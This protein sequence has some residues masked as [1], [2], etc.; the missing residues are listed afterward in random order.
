MDSCYMCGRTGEQ[1]AALLAL[2]ATMEI[3]SKIAALTK[4]K[5]S[6]GNEFGDITAL[7][8]TLNTKL[9]NLNTD[10]LNLNFE[11]LEKNFGN[12]KSN[13]VADVLEFMKKTPDFKLESFS[14]QHVIANFEK[15][16][17]K[18]VRM[19]EIEK[20]I[21]ELELRKRS[22][23]EKT[24]S[25]FQLMDSVVFSVKTDSLRSSIS[26]EPLD[27]AG[28]KGDFVKIPLCRI[29]SSLSKA[30]KQ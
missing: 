18:N 14:V 1:V 21:V 12:V 10:L 24:S 4:E 28:A 7:W 23:V 29:C 25:G 3:E 15:Y 17:P 27:P 2:E 30:F 22:V 26:F 9:K 20:E 6:L 16:R 11:T 19:E 5:Q 13:L 8:N